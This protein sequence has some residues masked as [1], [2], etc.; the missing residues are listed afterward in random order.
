MPDAAARRSRT[1]TPA[2][3]APA[4]AIEADFDSLIELITSTIAPPSWDSNGGAGSIA[5]FDTNLTLVVSQTQE[6]HEQIA[7]LLQQLR[8]LQD[9]QVTIEVRFITLDDD[10][11]ERI[12]VDFNFNIPTNASTATAPSRSTASRPS[13]PSPVVGLAS[14]QLGDQPA[15]PP[16]RPAP[17]NSAK[18]SI[19]ATPPFR[20]SPA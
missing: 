7:D 18:N 3:A 15:S 2:P 16:R 20:P 19:A 17:S 8:R 14:D 6:I 9:L 13:P 5:P 1:A 11:F 12:G 4:A 10:Y